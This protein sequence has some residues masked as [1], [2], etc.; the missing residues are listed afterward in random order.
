MTMKKGLLAACAVLMIAAAPALRADC[1]MQ[2]SEHGVLHL[3]SG[4]RRNVTWTAV[5]GATSYYVQDHIENLGDPADPDFTF[6]GPYTESRNG[7]GR[8]I[9]TYPFGHVV[10]YKM[11]F[12]LEVTAL[13]RS[14]PSF[15]PCTADFRYVVEADTEMA[16]VGSRRIIPLAG[17]TPGMGNSSYSTV[18][19]LSGTRSANEKDIY[20]GRIWFRPLGTTA[21]NQDPSIPYSI[22]GAETLLLDDVMDK[23]G[24][25]GIGTIE[26]IP[27]GPFFNTPQ[28]DAIIDNNNANGGRVSARIP[29]AW[30]RDYLVGA[31]SASIPIRN[32]TDAR[33]SI[34]MRGYGDVGGLV[35]FVHLAAD[36]T[37]IER[38]DDFLPGNTTKLFSPSALFKTPLRASERV[39]ASYNGIAFDATAPGLVQI[40]NGAKAALIFVTETGNVVNN[41]NVVYRDSTSSPRYSQG[42]E[43]FL[44][45]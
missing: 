24:A 44:V 18:L 31:D 7:E 42:F 28:V 14:D 32:M 39:V 30:G 38:V 10:L 3:K 15:H 6:G 22:D 35:S 26:V 17:K 2:L 45:R 23:L 9:T 4:E 40:A 12:R 43:P 27:L 37:F 19:I 33:L 29:A 1:T 11:T 5:P 34:G 21:S 25:S 8:G 36:G 41:P 20:Q 16:S 13:N